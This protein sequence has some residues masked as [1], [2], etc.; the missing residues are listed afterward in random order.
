M[1]EHGMCVSASILRLLRAAEYLSSHKVAG[2]E[3]EVDM[4][5][6]VLT[7]L[8]SGRTFGLK[9][10]GEVGYFLPCNVHSKIFAA[11]STNSCSIFHRQ[12][13]FSKDHCNLVVT[14]GQWA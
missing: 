11:H 13:L 1:L 8:S 5:A 6:N 2:L 3:V 4:E 10:L 7:E 9:P 12:N 14:I